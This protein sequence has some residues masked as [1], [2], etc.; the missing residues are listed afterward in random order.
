MTQNRLEQFRAIIL[1]DAKFQ[2]QLKA[3]DNQASF[4]KV[5]TQISE[6]LG[7]NF[8]V[9]EIQSALASPPAEPQEISDL[10]LSAVAGAGRHDAWTTLFGPCHVN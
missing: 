7:F 8:T 1:Q 4:I 9:D 3:V 10:E 2:D 5:M 6:K